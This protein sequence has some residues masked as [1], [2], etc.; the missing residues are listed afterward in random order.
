MARLEHTH[1]SDEQLGLLLSKSRVGAL[2]AAALGSDLS[3]AW[4]HVLSCTTCRTQFEL[5]ERAQQDFSNLKSPGAP[6]ASPTCPSENVWFEVALGLLDDADAER[7]VLHASTCDHCGPVL[8]GIAEAASIELTH[9]EGSAIE[10]LRSARPAWQRRLAERLHSG[11][12][13]RPS[14]EDI[15]HLRRSKLI[16]QT[17]TNGKTFP[18]QGW[19]HIPRWVYGVVILVS[20]GAIFWWQFKQRATPE[21]LLARAYSERRTIEMRIPGA[22]CAPMRQERASNPSH[23][24]RPTPLL[25][26]EALIARRLHTSPVD[27]RWLGAKGEAELLE[28]QYADA[29]HSFERAL[30]EDPNSS[31]LL[32]NLAIAYY[33]RGETEDRTADYG[34]AI[35][36]LGQALARNPNNWIALFNRAIANERMFLY[37]QA[38]LDWERFLQEQPASD[39]SHEARQRHDALVQRMRRR[40]SSDAVPLADPHA[41]TLAL[42]KRCCTL[43]TASEWP[44]SLDEAYLDVAMTQWL[45]KARSQGRTHEVAQPENDAS[46]ALAAVLVQFHHD[47]WLHDLLNDHFSAHW[48][49]AVRNL[50]LAVQ[51]NARGDPDHATALA[52]LAEEQFR[53]AQSAAGTLRA[54]YEYVVALKRAQRGSECLPL[55]LRLLRETRQHPYP[56]IRAATLLES[57]TCYGLVGNAGLAQALAQQAVGLTSRTSYGYLHLRSLCYDDG[58]GVD[59]P[60]ASSPQAWSRVRS[61][62]HQF[63]DGSYKPLPAFEFY[64]DLN[65]LAE[66]AQLWYLAELVAR[67]TTLMASRTEDR[68]Y[69]AVSHHW[70]AQVLQM[71]GDAQE[72]ETEFSLASDLFASLPSTPT[73]RSNWAAMEVY[74]ASLEVQRGDLDAASHRFSQVRSTLPE[75]ANSYVSILY[76]QWLGELYLRRGE[77]QPAERSLRAAVQVSEMGLTSLSNELDRLN[78]EREVGR[79]YRNLTELYF[80][81]Y[82]DPEKALKLWDWY[83]AVPFRA[84][85]KQQHT[86]PV[87][88]S[89][90]DSS[91]SLTS[92]ADEQNF[93]SSLSDETVVSFASFPTGL[94]IWVSDDRG[95]TARWVTVPSE[96]LDAVARRFQRMCSDPSSD[97]GLLERDSRQLYD[98]LIA[99]VL[100]NLE[101]KRTLV[102][103][104][105]GVLFQVPLQALM[106][107][108]GEY[109]EGQFSIV[110]SPGSA[111]FQGLRPRVRFSPYENVVVMG[112]GSLGSQSGPNFPPLPDADAEVRQVAVKFEHARVFVGSN[113]TIKTLEK[114]LPHADIFH[115]AGHAVSDGQHTGLLLSA[116]EPGAEGRPS[117]QLFRAS[118]I[119]PNRFMHTK[120]IVLSACETAVADKGLVDPENLVR[121]FLR[122]GV[123]NVIAAR[124]RIDSRATAETMDSFYSELVQGKSAAAALRIAVESIRKRPTMSHPYY[125]APLTAFGR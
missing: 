79:A 117:A 47:S 10:N 84:S 93:V 9:E 89:I 20:I 39:W 104:P 102:L 15:T 65:Y 58:V 37:D 1:L 105:D 90:L 100:A 35:D 46:K 92:I 23:L 113:A 123:P 59:A 53:S 66:G 83:R 2:N 52:L 54:R 57:S 44:D 67:E 29:I 34:K 14:A 55:A 28:G 119:G 13:A 96:T 103:E 3:D 38:L 81:N 26:A 107:P 62:L 32:S 31:V 116:V 18:L 80:R 56:W 12:S 41:A 7:F 64:G 51:A 71:A 86:T 73:S 50:S 43:K 68:A 42:R 30:D 40:D 94:A 108:Q 16:P 115:F 95:I 61:G 63:W 109:L 91:P 114:E 69:Q 19:L 27:P 110:V 98:W 22:A 36:L 33:Q 5:Y 76:Y 88:L 112:A 125:W 8:S 106:N 24:T 60:G 99:P 6:P 11:E 25:E 48:R 78:W 74:R 49:S 72:A 122:A 21:Q 17:K 75:I 111:Y 101:R 121:A 82:N 45:P 70:L 87:N 118:E 77:V 85:L 124:W 4:T 120:L 97:T